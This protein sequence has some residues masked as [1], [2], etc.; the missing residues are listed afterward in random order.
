MTWTEFAPQGKGQLIG[1]VL[2][3]TNE[4][5]ADVVFHGPDGHWYWELFAG[6]QSVDGGVA[7]SESDA[8]ARSVEAAQALCTELGGALEELHG[9]VA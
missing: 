3:L 1:H 4:I 5:R 8:K 2:I 6:R 9:E 7:L